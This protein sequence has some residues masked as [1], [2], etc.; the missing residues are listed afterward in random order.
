M[1]IIKLSFEDNH[2]QWLKFSWNDYC[3]LMYYDEQYYQYLQ[4]C[5]DRMVELKLLTFEDGK[6]TVSPLFLTIVEKYVRKKK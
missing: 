3:R 5:F 4:F 6:Y 2:N 1:N